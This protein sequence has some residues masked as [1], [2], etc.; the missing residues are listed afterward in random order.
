LDF[1]LVKNVSSLADGLKQN[2]HLE[3]LSLEHNLITNISGL[4]EALKVNTALKRLRLFNNPI[5]QTL[6][7]MFQNF[8]PRLR[9]NLWN[10]MST[11]AR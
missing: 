2:R 10:S 8:P 11:V 7:D 4:Q 5:N 6:E 9:S 1:N 3:I